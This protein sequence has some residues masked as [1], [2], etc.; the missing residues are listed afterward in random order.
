MQLKT[1]KSSLLKQPRYP[2]F[3]T[4]VFFAVIS[5]LTIFHND[6]LKEGDFFQYFLIG[7]EILDGNGTN[8]VALNANP[9]GPILY[10]SLDKV[11][12]DPLIVAKILGLFGGTGIVFVSYY[13][14]R[15]KDKEIII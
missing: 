2:F 13:V 6:F 3:I 9:G 11:F 12:H 14:M 15:N 5:Y 8:V 10:A 1:L 7:K 4:I